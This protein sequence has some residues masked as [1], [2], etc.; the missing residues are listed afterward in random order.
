MAALQQEWS[1]ALTNNQIA[2]NRDAIAQWGKETDI[3][4][5]ALNQLATEPSMKNLTTAKAAL[6]SFRSQFYKWMEPQA[7]Q[8]PYQVQVWNSRLTMIERLL[9]YG[10]RTAL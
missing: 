4:A 1:F 5:N 3:L 6:S 9:S 10:E 8:Q 7:L 2:I